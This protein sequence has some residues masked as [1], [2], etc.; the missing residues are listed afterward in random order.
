MEAY[1]I[2]A[3]L[4]LKGDASRKMLSFARAI[5]KA[6]KLL[7]ALNS[8]LNFFGKGLIIIDKSL[9]TINPRIKE[10]TANFSVLNKILPIT[11][12][13]IRRMGEIIDG[14]NSTSL[15]FTSS[16][17]RVS[18]ELRSVAAES[19][20]A[21]A[22]LN[23]LKNIRTINPRIRMSVNENTRRIRRDAY[24]GSRPN[25]RQ[26]IPFHSLYHAGIPGAGK[27]SALSSLSAWG[28]VGA[29]VAFGGA[30]F[31]RSGYESSMEYDKLIDQ[32]RAT[33]R[34]P[35]EMHQA[36]SSTQQILPG[37]SF[38]GQA[39]ALVDAQMAT[40][41]FSD[42]LKLAPELAKVGYIAKSIY[43]GL[44]EDQMKS[45]VR[46]A[47]IRG[48]SNIGDIANELQAVMHMYTVSGG[49]INPTDYLSFFRRYSQASKIT[50]E[51]LMALEP[52]MQE[53]KPT[54][55][56]TALQTLNQRLVGGVR[57]TQRDAGFFES[58][59]LF[60]GGRL[61]PKYKSILASDPEAFFEKVWFPLLNKAGITSNAD[62][63]EADVHLGNTPS[64]LAATIY[65]NREK[66]ARS[67]AQ[68]SGLLSM[69]QLMGVARNS[70]AGSAERLRQSFS[71]L[72]TSFGEFA[73]PGTISGMNMLANY[74]DHLS[75]IFQALSK[76]TIIPSKSDL[77]T[78][79]NA[80]T[81]R[82]LAHHTSVPVSHVSGLT[83]SPDSYNALGKM[84]HSPVNMNTSG[85]VHGD[86]YLDSKKVGDVIHRNTSDSL[87]RSGTIS[88]GSGINV[89]L[90]PAPT[91]VNTTGGF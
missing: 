73:K 85:Q 39:Q 6:D 34:S 45:A 49:T 63:L 2:W 31:A 33:G 28:G 19:T 12:A 24:F 77:K 68:Y 89:S 46:I 64:R 25:S 5:Q 75:E 56:G 81:F 87:N 51:A 40:R 71:S 22:S 80:L 83:I 41:R 82:N 67:R 76:I 43:S 48:G 21:A 14:T 47:E 11:N 61:D 62:I 72:A 8:K 70:Q 57:L 69:D 84:F 74:I 15:F 58:I 4:D 60:H 66:A 27:L 20:I 10:F 7:P 54:T 65:K 1:K 35:A 59:G 9:V 44:S 42:A 55:V 86:V 38:I 52:I 78:V 13:S 36:L 53:L 90:T 37:I 26:H 30:M 29:G 88:S 3:S 50:P 18:E 79:W 23:R 17:A 16:L 32:L 91:S